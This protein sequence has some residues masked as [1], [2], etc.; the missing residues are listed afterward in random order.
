MFNFEPAALI[1]FAGTI[2]GYICAYTVPIILHTYSLS[3]LEKKKLTESK[4]SG[5]EDNIIASTTVGNNNRQKEAFLS[6]A[7]AASIFLEEEKNSKLPLIGKYIFYFIILL[8][9][10][11]LIG[12]Q[13]S[14]VSC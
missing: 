10:T 11:F 8:Y 4:V 3:L 12:L 14:G 13:F 9:G 7:S 6:N 5:S 2:G 1:A